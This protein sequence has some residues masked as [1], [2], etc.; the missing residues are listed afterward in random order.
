MIKSLGFQ[1][2]T[3]SDARGF[4]G[5][6]WVLWNDSIGKVTVLS[7]RP[8]I[9]TLLIE[10][11]NEQPWVLSSVY[12]NPTPSIR[13]ELWEFIEKC[14]VFDDVAWMVIGDFNQIVSAE[15]HHDGFLGNS[16]LAQRMVDTLHSRGSW[17]SKLPVPDSL[18]LTITSEGILL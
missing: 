10:K 6:I 8:Q 3:K 4:S 11:N 15:E 2:F 18:G 14:T 5:G 16:R 7:I 12:A 9:I 1:Y 17:N 13:E